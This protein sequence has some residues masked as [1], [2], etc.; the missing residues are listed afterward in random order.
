V[1]RKAE[2]G[3]G[4]THLLDMKSILQGFDDADSLNVLRQ[5]YSIAIP[6]IFQKSRESFFINAPIVFGNHK[7]RFRNDLIEKGFYSNEATKDSSKVKA[8]QVLRQSIETSDHIKQIS[9]GVGDVIIIDNHR[10]LHGRTAF[11]D[12]DRLLYRIR[13]N[14]LDA[15]KKV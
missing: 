15:N 10:V 4:E 3:G 14:G 12:N 5:D 13:F 7:I 2:C 9:L 1:V 6:D 8:F 11:Q